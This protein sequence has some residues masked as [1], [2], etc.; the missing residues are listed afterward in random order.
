MYSERRKNAQD[1]PGRKGSGIETF[2]ESFIPDSSRNYP[3]T[4]IKPSRWRV[5]QWESLF[6]LFFQQTELTMKSSPPHLFYIPIKPVEPVIQCGTDL[7]ATLSLPPKYKVDLPISLSWSN[8]QNNL[9]W[10]LLSRVFMKDVL[11]GDE[12][13]LNM[14]WWRCYF[15]KKS[16]VLQ[17][18]G[19]VGF[20]T[21]S[22]QSLLTFIQ[23]LF[24]G[25]SQGWDVMENSQSSELSIR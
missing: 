11:S 25:L 3:Y 19:G 6:C 14:I 2:G 17:G 10:H 8:M 12:E 4:A 7:N 1:A 21:T 9:R 22:R 24:R 15:Q 13:S 5:L 18:R 20:E 23:F 16:G